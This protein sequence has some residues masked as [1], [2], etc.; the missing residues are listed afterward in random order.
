MRTETLHP[1]DDYIADA[2]NFIAFREG[3]EGGL[4]YFDTASP[5]R[6]TIG[7]GFNIEVTDYLLLVLNELGIVNETMTEAE[8]TARRQ[9]FTTA[10]NNTLD[11]GN[12]DTINDQLRANLNQVSIQYGVTTFQLNTTQGYN[13]F[14]AIILGTNIGDVAIQGKQQ[15]LDA[16]LDG[17]L[18]RNS[19]EYI[20]VMSLFYNGETLVGINLRRALENDN[21]AEAWYEIRYRSNGGDSPSTGIANRRYREAALFG[22]Y[23][24]GELTPEQQTDQAKEIMRMYTIHELQETIHRQKL[25]SYETR[26]AR[27]QGI[28]AIHTEISPAKQHLIDNFAM[29]RT[30]DGEVIVGRGLD[31]YA[32][33]DNGSVTDV[34][35]GTYWNDLIFGE[36]GND[37][38]LG[39]LGADVIY[40]GEGDDHI[41]GGLGNDLLY[42]GEGNDTY[43]VHAGD[44]VDTIEDKEGNNRVI[45]CGIEINFFYDAGAGQYASPDGTLTGV[46]SGGDFIVTHYASGTKVI[47]NE[48]FQW[49]DFGIILLPSQEEATIGSVIYLDVEDPDHIN[50]RGVHY[51]TPGHDLIVGGVGDDVIFGDM[52]A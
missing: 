34:L 37:I 36:K 2:F 20:A 23:D 50:H 10:I 29:G 3:F 46:M 4:P 11:T 27:P 41:T 9:E 1:V 47:L 18:V 13:V 6:A 35:T 19:N 24:S 40:G 38:I 21:R 32:Y 12:I 49:G 15:R 16:L 17:A 52:A 43:Y 26:Y 7:Y 51:G 30:I 5:R 14:R 39:G 42:G 45:L 33:K 8:I 48:D 44:G 22:L 28:N 31:S 25:S